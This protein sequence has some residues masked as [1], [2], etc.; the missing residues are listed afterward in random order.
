MKSLEDSLAK[1][2]DQANKKMMR[3]HVDGKEI[4][5]ANYIHQLYSPIIFANYIRQLYSPIIPDT[6]DSFLT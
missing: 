1:Q 6:I 2:K 5:F 3:L 4:I